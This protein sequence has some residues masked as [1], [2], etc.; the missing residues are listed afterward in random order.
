MQSNQATREIVQ[1]GIKSPPDAAFLKDVLG[2]LIFLAA[3]SGTA[4]FCLTEHRLA[5]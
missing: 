5:Q 2:A 1:E 3:A 4:V